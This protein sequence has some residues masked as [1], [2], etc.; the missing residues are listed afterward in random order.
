MK[1]S[2]FINREVFNLEINN[3]EIFYSDRKWE[4]SIRLVPKDEKFLLKVSMSRNKIPNFLINLF[5]LNDEEIK[6]YLTAET[7]EQLAQICIRD[8]KRQGAKLIKKDG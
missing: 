4:K 5:N 6:E 7:D 2:F 1:L 3:R 8:C